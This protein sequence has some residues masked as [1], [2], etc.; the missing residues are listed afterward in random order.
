MIRSWRRVIVGEAVT[1][2]VRDRPKAVGQ[3]LGGR[4][5]LPVVGEAAVDEDDRHP[6]ASVD[7]V[8]LD[9]VHS[10]CGR[11]RALRSDSLFGGGWRSGLRC[12]PG[13]RQHKGG[14]CK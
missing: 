5:P 2:A 7:I 3:C 8:Q 13:E 4:N 14:G 12:C 11:R 10:N 1:A 6:R 9:S